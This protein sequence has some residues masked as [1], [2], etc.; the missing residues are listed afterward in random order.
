MGRAKGSDERE[1]LWLWPRCRNS[2][3][4]ATRLVV[5]GGEKRGCTAFLLLWEYEPVHGCRGEPGGKGDRGGDRDRCPF[6]Q[7][8]AQTKLVKILEFTNLAHC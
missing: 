8:V 2:A 7:D 3:E 6:L 4:V 5:C 1:Q